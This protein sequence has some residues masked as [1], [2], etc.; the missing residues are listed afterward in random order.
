MPQSSR[1]II[2]K[3]QYFSINKTFS[4]M[5]ISSEIAEIKI[6]GQKCQFGD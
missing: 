1:I 5:F 2:K 6:S 4:S 3:S